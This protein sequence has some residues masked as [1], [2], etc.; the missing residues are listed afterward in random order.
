[1]K[2]LIPELKKLL[3]IKL[4]LWMMAILIT[5][6][7]LLAYWHSVSAEKEN[8][9]SG[10]EISHVVEL[11]VADP[12]A[13]ENYVAELKEYRKA[14]NKLKRE[15]KALG[16]EFVETGVYGIGSGIKCRQSTTGCTGRREQFR[17]KHNNPYSNFILG[18]AHA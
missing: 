17:F 7:G 18:S 2:L 14:Q 16:I 5:A 4:L 11:Y 6:N 8:G 9:F 15:Y 13:V 3:S 12:E 10:K 1:M